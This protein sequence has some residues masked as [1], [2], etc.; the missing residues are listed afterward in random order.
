MNTAEAR[1]QYFYC[2]KTLGSLPHPDVPTRDVTNT[3]GA[4]TKTEPHLEVRAEN[5]CRCRAYF[6][7]PAVKRARW[8]EDQGGRHYLFLTTR[9]PSD[10]R[11]FVVGV[12]PFS[13]K[14]LQRL[15]FRFPARWSDETFL[16]YVSGDELKLV[17]FIDAYPLGSKSVPGGQ[18][19]RGIVPEDLLH[20]VL[21]HLSAK[22]DRTE[23]FLDNVHELESRLKRSPV[24]WADYRNRVTK[25]AGCGARA[26]SKC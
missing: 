26:R 25:G 14:A 11:P 20:E 21:A 13:T 23:E 15:M 4:G 12:M 22:K 7:T 1:F 3:R 9:R 2:T 18:G 6:I 16:P 8:L 19:G 17:S 10:E 5:W 24:R